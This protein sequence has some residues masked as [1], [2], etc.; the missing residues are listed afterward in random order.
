MGGLD[1]APEASPSC[2]SGSAFTL[3]TATA[4]AELS[5]SGDL[6]S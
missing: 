1:G 4:L 6:S 3:A 2:W 5:A